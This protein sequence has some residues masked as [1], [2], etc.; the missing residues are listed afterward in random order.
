MRAVN[1]KTPQPARGHAVSRAQVRPPAQSAVV[2]IAPQARLTRPQ[3]FRTRREQAISDAAYFRW[4]Y[5][6]CAAGGEVADWLA[7][8]QEVDEQLALRDTLIREAAYARWAKRGRLHGQDV[9]DWMAAE[10]EVDASLA[11]RGILC[12]H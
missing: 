9:R 3:L 5:R 2:K 12:G 1:F 10:A 8:E 7:A 6:G 4:A 11:R